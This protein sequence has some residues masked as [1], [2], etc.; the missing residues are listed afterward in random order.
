MRDLEKMGPF[1]HLDFNEFLEMNDVFGDALFGVGI[2]EI[3]VV[4]VFSDCYP[5]TI[6]KAHHFLQRVPLD[7]SV[8]QIPDPLRIVVLSLFANL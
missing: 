4:A 1:L 7:S 3:V 6:A 2:E 8:H 5:V